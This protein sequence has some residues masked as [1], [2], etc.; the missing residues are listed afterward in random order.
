MPSPDQWRASPT[1]LL[2][3][4]N[5]F[6]TFETKKNP[7][8]DMRS[9]GFDEDRDQN[10]KRTEPWRMRA[11][12]AVEVMVPSVELVVVAAAGVPRTG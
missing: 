4:K 10:S 8:S 11:V 5:E 12:L 6:S 2:K 1:I 3:L 9:A 7:Q